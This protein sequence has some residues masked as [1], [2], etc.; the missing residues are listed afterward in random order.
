MRIFLAVILPFLAFNTP[1]ESAEWFQSPGTTSSD[2]SIDKDA[3]L[4]GMAS[5]HDGTRLI[6]TTHWVRA[7]S[8]GIGSPTRTTFRCFDTYEPDL[9][10]VSHTCFIPLE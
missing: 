10:V 4:K 6:I 3:E 8:L 5:A 2:L 9:S 1:A 7:I